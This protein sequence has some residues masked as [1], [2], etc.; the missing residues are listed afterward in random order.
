[1]QFHKAFY[2][3]HGIKIT[4]EAIDK[5][6]TPDQLNLERSINKTVKRYIII[7][8]TVRMIE[9]SIAKYPKSEA[10]KNYL[11]IACV[12]VRQ[13][14]KA[15]DCLHNTIKLHPNYAFGPINLANYYINKKELDKA[16][17]LFSEPY[18]VRS[19]EKMEFIN[20]SI[21]IA[22]YQSVV[23]LELAKGNIKIDEKYHQLMFEYDPKDKTVQQL[24]EDIWEG[25][26]AAMQKGM[27]AD[28]ILKD[29]DNDRYNRFLSN[30]FSD[31]LELEE[32]S[33]E[34]DEDDDH[35]APPQETVRRVE[36]KLGRNDSCHCGSGKKY[37]KCHGA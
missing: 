15:L 23:M 17:A 36:P 6:Q 14:D 26:M 29:L 13:Y 8:Q 30:G 32:P 11:Y 9:E 12:K 4:D 31:E 24:S 18:D 34:Y 19:V 3:K 1:M 37:K 5:G 10:L 33:E 27:L 2:E 21:F 25:R 16:S 28:E 20:Y 7:P 22:Y 35:Y